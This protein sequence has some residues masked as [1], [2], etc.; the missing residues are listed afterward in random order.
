[1][2]YSLQHALDPEPQGDIE[3][4]KAAEDACNQKIDECVA[5]SF[6]DPPTSGQRARIRRRA[7]GDP[8]RITGAFQEIMKDSFGLYGSAPLVSSPMS[9]PRSSAAGETSVDWF[10]R[11][12]LSVQAVNPDVLQLRVEQ[13]VGA[14]A[15]TVTGRP[16]WRGADPA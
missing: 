8:R 16:G 6:F 7:E 5:K 12:L 15:G 11:D 4:S 1:M 9:S 14:A 3:V 10:P 2:K 13:V